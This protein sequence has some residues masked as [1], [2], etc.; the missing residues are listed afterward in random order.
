[1][2]LKGDDMQTGYKVMDVMT[3]K[4]VVA[5]KELLLKE[6]AKI[7]E[8]T[9]VNSLLIVENENPIGIITDED[10][11]RKVVAKGLDLKKIRVKDIM[12]TELT[13]ISPEKDIYD[14]L[15]LMRDRNI[16]QLPVVGNNKL[17]GF[18]T[19]KD[20]LKIEPELID[21]F[22]EKYELREESRKLA[23]DEDSDGFSDFFRKL[24]LKKKKS[25]KRKI[26]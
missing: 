18:L 19:S 26:L 1:M 11:V 14:A 16:R 6:A 24:G 2:S 21:L 13:T 17:V 25:K 5:N 8:D 20:I 9:N 15:L 10:V 23:E 12:A 22:V 4:P 7:M 3:N